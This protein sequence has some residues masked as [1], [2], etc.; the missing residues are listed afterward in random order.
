MR[1]LLLIF[2]TTVSLIHGAEYQK[3]QN[4]VI[5]HL[6]ARKRLA[7]SPG[8]E[9]SCHILSIP[10]GGGFAWTAVPSPGTLAKAYVG[11]TAAN[12]F[13]MA[14][15]PTIAASLY[16]SAFDDSKE[17]MLAILLLE[18]QGDAVLG[19]S[20][21]LY[22]SSFTQVPIAKS[23]A[24][25]TVPYVLSLVKFI[26][27]GQATAL[28]FDN[29]VAMAM[30]AS[31]ALP[32][33]NIFTAGPHMT[34][35]ASALATALLAYGSFGSINAIQSASVE[36]LDITASPGKQVQQVQYEILLI[37]RSQITH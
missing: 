8:G 18:R 9:H 36:G 19:T 7:P 25:S 10:R 24:W 6:E 34:V 33:L 14:V 13:A 32:T 23:V 29:R 26:C 11:F 15:L 16:G 31:L 17:S 37:K 28:S 27:L 4:V 1:L 3:S 2:A 22:L 35:A 20:I 30:M 5:S 21:L 12:G